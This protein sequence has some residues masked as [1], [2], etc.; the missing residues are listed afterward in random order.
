MPFQEALALRVVQVQG[1]HSSRHFLEVCI[2]GD[3]VRPFPTSNPGP[4]CHFGVC[5]SFLT[6]MVQKTM[7][8][9]PSSTGAPSPRLGNRYLRK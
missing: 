6:G 7:N 3:C 8:L 9:L 2:L 4:T 5:Y 1:W